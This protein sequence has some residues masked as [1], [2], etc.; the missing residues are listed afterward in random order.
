[1]KYKLINFYAFTLAEVLITLLVIGVVTA[2]VVP[3]II[4]NTQNAELRVAWKKAYS[5]F[6]QVAT[7]FAMYNNGNLFGVFVGTDDAANKFAN[8]M[9]V[10]KKCTAG[11]ALGTNGCWAEKTYNFSGTAFDYWS[12]DTWSR[13]V[14]NNGSFIAFGAITYDCTY[15]RSAK[16]DACTTIAIDINGFR[17]PNTVGK[18][19]FF[20]YLT[21]P[22]NF[23]PF[24][25]VGDYWTSSQHGCDLTVHSN[26]YGFTCGILY[27]SQ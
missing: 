20:G 10:T 9:I 1:M 25:T 16:Q 14:L 17:G 21:K 13:M 4:N 24:G 19:I 2:V 26:A 8:Y 11:T 12:L 18:D 27:L 7:E 15:N 23:E 22:G 6:S 5:D 3:N